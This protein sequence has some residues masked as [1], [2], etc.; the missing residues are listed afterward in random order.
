MLCISFSIVSSSIVKNLM[1]NLVIDWPFFLE[2]YIEVLEND[3][4]D[5]RRLPMSSLDAYF[6]S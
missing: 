3:C 1:V 5:S 6:E 2:L 4:R